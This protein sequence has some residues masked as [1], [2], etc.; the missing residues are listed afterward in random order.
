[1]KIECDTYD[2]AERLTDLR[3]QK[4]VSA[5]DM[6]LS[7]GQTSSYIN[8]IENKSNLPSM[9]TFFCICEYL[10]ITPLDFFN[11][12]DESPLISNELIKEIRM[13]NTSQ[14]NLIYKI[15]K[16][17][18]GTTYL[19]VEPYLNYSIFLIDSSIIYCSFFVLLLMPNQ[20]NKFFKTSF[21]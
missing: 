17:I 11:Y 14:T 10:E 5:R 16:E 12:D 20:R 13:L 8:N 7:M 9:K 2:F 19:P 18:I 6:S 21:F 1:M 3:I 4:G 15:L